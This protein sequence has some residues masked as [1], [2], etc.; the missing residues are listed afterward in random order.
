[1][2]QTAKLPPDEQRTLESAA[3]LHDIGLVG[4]PRHIIRR[5]QEDP[6]QLPDAERALIEQHPILGQEL[7]A[8]VSQLDQVGYI[9]RGHHERFDGHGYPDQRA[10]ESIPGSPGSLAMPAAFASL[11]RYR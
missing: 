6:D 8:F 9:I 1:M 4:I 3:L 10:G 11:S 2:G 7:A 5:W